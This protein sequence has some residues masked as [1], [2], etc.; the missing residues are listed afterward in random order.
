MINNFLIKLIIIFF[1]FFSQLLI[2]EDLDISSKSI[3]VDKSNKIIA[4]QGDVKIIDSK[5]N[6]ISSEKIKYDKIKQILN[7][8]GKTEILF[9]C[10]RARTPKILKHQ[11]LA[12]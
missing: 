10:A 8:F 4:A 7:T 3:E 9:R 6:I 5:N 1:I 2:A 12:I 11:L